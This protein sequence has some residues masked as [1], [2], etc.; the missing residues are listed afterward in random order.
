MAEYQPSNELA[1]REPSLASRSSLCEDCLAMKR[2]LLITVMIAVQAV[3]QTPTPAPAGGRGQGGRGGA[4]GAAGGGGG[5]FQ[6]APDYPVRPAADPAVVDRGKAIYGVSCAFCHG[7]EARGGEGGPS[8]IRSQLV[9]NDKN[10]ELITP[11]VQN[12]RPENGMPRLDLTAAQVSDIAAFL[13]NFKVGGYD[14]SRQRP[15]S[16][17][18][19][20]AKA[21]EAY[22]KSKCAAC[23]SIDGDL[24]GFAAKFTEP[25]IMQQTW[26]MPSGG[27]RGGPAAGVTKVPPTTVT[28]TLAS[29]QKVEGKLV[30][31]D[32]FIVTLSDS[33]DLQRTFRRAG[34]VP[35]V[36]IHDP[37]Q[38]HRD[39][40]RGYADKDI[41]N[42]TAYLESLK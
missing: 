32:D 37:L 11:V 3:S 17:L 38:P 10:G 39:L 24:K 15:P 42:V 19:G 26:L 40:L 36:E 1:P 14:I 29:G 7:A 12:G 25:R 2:L 31:I 23:H 35:K 22:F 20:D 8:L 5:G 41:H 6:R 16:I 9:L 34:D 28:V 21:G 27:G 13:H 4:P 33:D 18:V 30:R